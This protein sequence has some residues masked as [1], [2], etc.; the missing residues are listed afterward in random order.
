VEGLPLARHIQDLDEHR[1]VELAAALANAER[2]RLWLPA[3]TVELS[4]RVKAA[5]GGV[6]GRTYL[7]LDAGGPFPLGPRLWQVKSGGSPPNA[8]REFA[9]PR[10]GQPA[11]DKWLV[12][13]L[14]TGGW[15]YVLFWTHDPVDPGAEKVRDEFNRK[16]DAISPDIPRTFLFLSQI[17]G[18]CRH[19]PAPSLSVLG[20][21][22]QGV[23][24]P[25]SW[26][27]SFP[28]EFIRDP[29]REAIIARIREVAVSS[30]LAT[31]TLRLFGHAGVGK[32]RVAYEAISESGI[33]ERTLVA[34]RSGTPELL[35]WVAAAHVRSS[36]LRVARRAQ[37]FDLVD[38]LEGD[39]FAVFHGPTSS[40][41]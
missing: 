28:G 5:D 18:L 35:E 14:R 37:D 25:R 32:S 31:A 36:L 13:Q 40:I 27:P 4:Y 7:P 3:D 17:V 2:G 9:S 16:L 1:A 29:A 30:D 6:D 10:R 24:A 8:G 34:T 15:G 41:V 23:I 22:A 21:P 26:A 33:E 11:Q 39:E 12:E 19:H 20:V 38:L